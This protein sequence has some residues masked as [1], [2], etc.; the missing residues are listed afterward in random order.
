VRTEANNQLHA[1]M[2]FIDFKYVINTPDFIQAEGSLPF[3]EY[4]SLLPE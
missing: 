3:S 4:A 2:L 1:K